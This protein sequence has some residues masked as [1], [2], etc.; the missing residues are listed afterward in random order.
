MD[1]L[2]S[3]RTKE[4]VAKLRGITLAKKEQWN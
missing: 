3:L 4:E 2:Q 1:G